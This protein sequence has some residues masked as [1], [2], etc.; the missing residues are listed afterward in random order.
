MLHEATRRDAPRLCHLLLRSG[1]NPNI[2][3]NRSFLPLHY[4]CQEGYIDPARLLLLFGSNVNVE[5]EYG[6]SPIHTATRYGH[7]NIV[8]LLLTTEHRRNLDEEALNYE[9]NEH[10]HINLT[11]AV[12]S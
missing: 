6:D 4:A 11:N 7:C 10:Q 8:A 5:N 12:R 2:T 1:A 9:W 3:D